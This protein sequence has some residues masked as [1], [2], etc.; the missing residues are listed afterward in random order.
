[1]KNGKKVY[2]TQE[3]KEKHVQNAAPYLKLTYEQLWNRIT[4]Q[5]VPR[6]YGLTNPQTIGCPVCGRG[7]APY[8]NYPYILDFLHAPWKLT[9]P[10]CKTQFPTNDFKTYYE[11][12]LDKNGFFNP[13]LAKAHNDALIADGETG[14]LVNL[15]Y[16]EKGSTWGVDDSTGFIA[17]NGQKYTFVAYYN[18]FYLSDTISNCL[19]ALKNAYLATE[20]VAYANRAVVLLDRIADVYPDMDQSLWTRENGFLNANGGSCEKGKLFG[21]ISECSTMCEILEAIEAISPTL[22]DISAS[23]CLEALEF[24]KTK[25]PLRNSIAAVREH[26]E[27]GIIREVFPA[28]KTTQIYGNSGMHQETLAH[29]AVL[30]DQYPETREWLEFDFQ[31]GVDCREGIDGGGIRSTMVNRIDRDGH[32][33]ESSPAY[34]YVWIYHYMNIANILDGYEVKGTAPETFDFIHHVKLRKMVASQIPL[35]LS[36]IYMPAIAD[37]LACGKPEIL[38]KLP[39]VIDAFVKYG[40]PIFAQAAYLINGNTL[41]GMPLSGY[42]QRPEEIQN[43]IL[44]VIHTYGT[45]SLSGTNLTGYGLAALRDGISGDMHTGSR[46]ETTQRDIWMY[47]GKTKNKRSGHGHNDSLNLGLHAYGLDLMPDLGYPR[48]ADPTDKHRT[49]VVLNTLMHNTVTVD[50]TQHSPRIVGQPLHFHQG[51]RVKLIDVS[52]TAVYPGITDTYRRTAAMIRINERDSYVVDIFR[53]SGGSTHCYSFHSG[54]CDFVVTEGLPLVKQADENGNFIGTYAGADL[55]YPVQ[56]NLDDRTGFHY[57]TN[58]EKAKGEIDGFT[59]DYNVRDTWN[60]YGEG[61]G[62]ET[63]VHLKLTSL[64]QFSEV[65]LAD[66]FP[67]ET[68][69]GNPKKIRYVLARRN[70]LNLQSCFT[71]IL[72]PYRGEGNISHIEALPVKDSN[73]ADTDEMQAR[74]VKVTLKNGRVDYIVNA[75]DPSIDYIALDG[76]TSVPFRGFFGVF[77]IENG[78][79]HY[80]FNDMAFLADQA[81]DDYP[82]LTGTVVDFTQDLQMKNTISVQFDDGSIPLHS[83]SGSYVYIENDGIQNASYRIETAKEG[84]AGTVILDIGDVTPIRSYVDEYDFDKGYLYDIE[85]GKRFRIPLALEK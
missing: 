24:I 61:A 82:A 84:K 3:E 59:A 15:L 2:F 85:I 75:V 30:L 19:I 67:P 25:H 79:K 28:V 76:K 8:G 13:V 74:A 22:N 20:D 6:S 32:G 64:G 49:S 41:E 37:A 58:V 23:P 35:I 47:Y 57:L 73:G 83:L 10:N 78:V 80:Y 70:G 53:V 68:K 5:L 27:D 33:D 69:V 71:S 51:N 4:S 50:N 1:M 38:L 52:D 16:P 11:G 56:C 65:A 29:A 17:E 21:S 40:D 34:H 12:G 45:L 55:P 39:V 9:C 72:E 7:V 26:I 60:I 62:A 42:E 48:Y 66:V 54:E 14:N 36:D 18:F 31:S 46:K 77:S 44:N 63:N 81:N 43:N